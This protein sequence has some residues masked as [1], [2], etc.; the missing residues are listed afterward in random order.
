MQLVEIIIFTKAT[1]A[2]T[3]EPGL[4]WLIKGRAKA[5]PGPMGATPLYATVANG[6]G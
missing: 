3:T 4:T 6:A 5:R 1:V 2:K